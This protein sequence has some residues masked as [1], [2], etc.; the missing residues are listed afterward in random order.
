M[1]FKV[2]CE[3]YKS[4]LMSFYGQIIA[5]IFLKRESKRINLIEY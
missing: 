5:D 3:E 4:E 2:N 1:F